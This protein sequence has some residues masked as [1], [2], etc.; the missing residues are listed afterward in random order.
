VLTRILFAAALAFLGARLWL[1]ARRPAPGGRLA[2]LAGPPL[3]GRAEAAARTFHRL[4]I[5]PLAWHFVP[6]RL[7]GATGI[8][9]AV[10]LAIGLSSIVTVAQARRLPWIGEGGRAYRVKLASGFLGAFASLLIAYWWL[11]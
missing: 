11:A 9:L 6:W 8:R 1:E 7:L 4:A 2:R 5:L 10:V 3:A